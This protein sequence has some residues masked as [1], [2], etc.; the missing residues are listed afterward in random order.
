MKKV[1]VIGTGT[2]GNGIAHVLAINNYQVNLVG[3]SIDKVDKAIGL[4][5]KNI[6]RQVKKELIS[7]EDKLTSLSNIVKFVSLADA[8]QGVDMV[9]EAITEDKKQKVELFTKLGEYCGEEIVLASNTSSISLTEIASKVKFPERVIGVHFMN[10]VPVM[11][12]VEIITGKLTN[13]NTKE[14][15]LGLCTSLSK[16]PVLVNDAPGFIANRILMPMINEAILSLEEGVS[17]VVEIDTIMKLGMSHPIGPLQLADL[18]GLD[19]CYSI[20]NVMCE[21]LGNKYKPCDLL[22]SLV[23]SKTL[24]VKTGQGFYVHTKGSK[25]LVVAPRFL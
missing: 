7:P 17:G 23:E 18:I 8:V 13:E 20:L 25:E 14:A 12:L 4:I 2:M 6:E 24:G 22:K 16:E 19:V 10:P 11:K 3:T 1:A 9:I 5:S 15:A 21:G